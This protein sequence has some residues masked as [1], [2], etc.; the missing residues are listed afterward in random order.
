MGRGGGRG[1]SCLQLL[2]ISGVGERRHP[3][4]RGRLPPMIKTQDKKKKEKEKYLEGGGG[5]NRPAFHPSLREKEPNETRLK[6][7]AEES[8][9]EK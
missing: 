4:T 2:T 6:T 5:K 7:I 8:K 9:G 3:P 1:L